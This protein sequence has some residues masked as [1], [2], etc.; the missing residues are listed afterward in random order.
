MWTK[1]S[2][3][4]STRRRINNNL[5]RTTRTSI[6]GSKHSS[7]SKHTVVRPPGRSGAS[8]P[9]RRMI[10]PGSVA[11][12]ALAGQ[13][14]STMFSGHS[15]HSRL[16]AHIR[17]I[18]NSSKDME[19]TLPLCK[20]VIPQGSVPRHQ[21]ISRRDLVEVVMAMVMETGASIQATAAAEPLSLSSASVDC[22]EQVRRAIRGVF[23]DKPPIPTCNTSMRRVDQV[24]AVLVA[25]LH[26]EVPALGSPASHPFHSS[27]S[28]R[29]GI[30]KHKGVEVEGP[31]WASRRILDRIHRASC[32][33]ARRP[34][35]AS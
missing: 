35:R 6:S 30:L 12:V 2:T 21:R 19:P 26:L 22:Q 27:I 8:R 18:C 9:G 7:S 10:G 11:M 13:G 33:L 29:L 34:S 24:E 14:R 20:A 23:V 28:R 1:I 31:D 25:Q 17:T 32:P 15:R 4:M 5:L 3:R 16:P